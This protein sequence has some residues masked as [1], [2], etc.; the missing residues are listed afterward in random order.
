MAA[1]KKADQQTE[2]AVAELLKTVLMRSRAAEALA[3]VKPWLDLHPVASQSAQFYAG[4]SLQTAGEWADAVIFYRKILANKSLDPKLAAYVVPTTYRLLINDMRQP[5]SAYLL[6]REDGDRLREY[7]KASQF[8]AWFLTEAKR[9]NDVVAVC[10]RLGTIWGA[11]TPQALP[12]TADLEWVCQKLESFR[13]EDDTWY[14]A[15][16]KLAGVAQIPAG[17]K[18]RIEWASA[19]VSCNVKVIEAVRAGKEAPQSLFAK[20]LQAASALLAARPTEGSCWWPRVDGFNEG[21]TPTFIRH[22]A[23]QREAKAAQLL[24]VLQTL[25]ADKARAVLWYQVA[26][27]KGRSITLLFSAAEMRGLVQRLP[28]LFNTLSAPNVPL[29]D[30]DM[31]AAEAKVVAP[32]L[33]RN[34]QGQAALVRATVAAG[35]HDLNGVFTT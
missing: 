24:S 18:A 35:T 15:A 8:D 1:F 29:Y 25:P 19:V 22:L 13:K 7:G 10:K 6:M 28:A 11:V 5:E 23:P 21:D 14:E 12:D 26:E 33:A 16:Q 17:Y 9:R 32:L 30:K 2:E 4:L 3:V 34:P 31:K 27:S 20:P